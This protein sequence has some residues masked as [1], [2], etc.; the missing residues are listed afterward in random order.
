MIH[1]I[2][3]QK[4]QTVEYLID[5][6]KLAKVDILMDVRS[7]PYSRKRQFNKSVLAEKLRK[8]GISYEWVG[9]KLGG[10][11]TIAEDDI[12][13]LA[14]YEEGK[15][16]CLMCM[17]AEPEKCHRE[18]EIGHRLRRFGVHVVHIRT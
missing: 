7:K 10:F 6:L 9:N 18:Y 8:A 13:Y 2:G 11:G 14:R 1:T 17:E 16:I 4:L 3:Y 5:T 15:S 12:E